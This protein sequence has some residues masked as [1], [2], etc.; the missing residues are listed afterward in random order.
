MHGVNPYFWKKKWESS[1]KPDIYK[2]VVT[3]FNTILLLVRSFGWEKT[4]LPFFPACILCRKTTKISLQKEQHYLLF[5]ELSFWHGK[6]YNGVRVICKGAA[7]CMLSRVKPFKINRKSG[8]DLT[9]RDLYITILI[10]V[11]T[12][13][14]LAKNTYFMNHIE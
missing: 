5:V 14:I 13:H 3:S 2:A 8:F 11:F 7:I 9:T 1:Y 10:E 4:C 6:L 12:N